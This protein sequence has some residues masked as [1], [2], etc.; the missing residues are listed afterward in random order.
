MS[1]IHYRAAY[2]DGANVSK[3]ALRNGMRDYIP[4][5]CTVAE[6]RDITTAGHRAAM[7]GGSIYVYDS[8]DTTSA[9]DGINCVL[10]ADSLRY[11][12]QVTGNASVVFNGVGDDATDNTDAMEDAI[13]ALSDGDELVIPVGT[14]RVTPFT[15]DKQIRLRGITKHGSILKWTALG[16]NTRAVTVE[17]DNVAFKSL[18]LQGPTIGSYVLGE[19]GI[20]CVGQDFYE[21]RQNLSVEDCEIS[22]FGDSGIYGQ[23]IEG[24]K[25]NENLI[26]DCGYAGMQLLSCNHG[27][28]LNN[29]IDSITPG[30]SSNMY[31]IVL[32]HDS[33]D[34]DLNSPAIEKLVTNPFC[35]DWR[36]AGNVVSRINW[37]GIDCHGGYEISIN[38]N[39]IYAT[40]QGIACSSSS[41]DATPYAG[42]QN[43]VCNNVVDSRHRN[44]SSSGLENTAFGININ[45]G[46]IIYNR[47][48]RVHGNIV[49]YKGIASNSNTGSIQATFG[50]H[51]SIS[52]NIIE[53][54]MGVA[55]LATLATGKISGNLLGPR[56]VATDTVATCILDDS[57]ST[58]GALTV[59][60]NNHDTL[61]GNAASV[62]FQQSAT[63]TYRPTLNGNNFTQATTQFVLSTAD[64][65]CVGTD[66]M[67][68]TVQ[69]GT[70]GTVAIGSLGGYDCIIEL[71]NS[72]SW[73]ITNVTGAQRGQ[74]VT[75]VMTGS[76]T[77]TF[78]RSNA[79]LAGS[80]NATIGPQDTLVLQKLSASNWH[81]L[82]RA[83][84]G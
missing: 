5:F 74:K 7:I 77:A 51:V 43:S 36:I 78:D 8:S 76:G 30:S 42:F 57:P 38:D 50:D 69:S 15:I 79:Y 84:N 23:F 4:L 10:S 44:G 82:S 6:L 65:F 37:I 49:R 19:N 41:G 46:S 61:G 39:K 20:H 56:A 58:V 73:T 32:T 2:V 18:G 3:T 53:Q 24:V 66:I 47:R 17:D 60:N 28:A 13:S 31:G 71:T 21:R 72:G 64:G 70:P 9:D 29:D 68:R 12:R 83:A 67:P 27:K 26:H 14:F 25:C 55:V 11:K 22:G 1:T 48:I 52:D 54:W 33:T 81:E 16:A 45:G 59:E 35:W 80:A 40:G 63:A 34:Y 75:L 62:G